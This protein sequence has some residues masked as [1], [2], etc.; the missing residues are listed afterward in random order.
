[1]TIEPGYILAITALMGLEW[2]S[3]QWC[4]FYWCIQSLPCGKL[5]IG[6]HSAHVIE[7]DYNILEWFCAEGFECA[8]CWADWFEQGLQISLAF[9]KLSRG[10]YLSGNDLRIH[11]LKH[12]HLFITSSMLYSAESIPCP[13]DMSLMRY[14]LMD[15]IEMGQ[16]QITESIFTVSKNLT[17][18]Q[19]ITIYLVACP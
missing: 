17:P 4:V 9:R 5:S 14:V 10:S 19:I 8:G 6:T 11:L 2:C 1:M 13:L 3:V 15:M 16:C 7:R 18:A 12:L